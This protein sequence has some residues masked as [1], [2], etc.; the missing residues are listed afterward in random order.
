LRLVSLPASPATEPSEPSLRR[1]AWLSIG[2]ALLTI[3][4]KSLAYLAT[5]S[6]GL[7]SDALESL[8]NLVAAIVALIVL[9]IAESPADEEH[10]WGHEK[11]EYFSSGFEGAAILAAAVA[12]MFTAI[13]RL[14]D[15]KPLESVGLGL[16]ISV[17]ASVVN[18]V[19][20]RILLAAG[21]KHRS[22]TLEADGHH[23]MTDVWTSVGVVVGVGLVA[24]TDIAWL[25]PLVAI[26]VALNIVWTGWR[27]LVRSAMGLLDSSV[28]K[29]DR[30]GFEAILQRYRDD[31]G[32]EW[33]ALRTRQSGSRR[34][35]TVHLLVPGSWTVQRGHD[36][37][38]RVERDLR[39]TSPKTTVFTHLEP[40]EDDISFH[41][42]G[43]DRDSDVPPSAANEPLV[44]S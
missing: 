11:V 29:D 28:S 32:I 9:T 10:E 22:I 33:H 43:L 19:V 26:G 6:V 14:L 5:G 31:E 1:F 12:I 27:L 21:K 3:A 39:G 30:A 40:I 8:V 15:P 24:L 35:V 4:L 7:L 38:E 16:V 17:L 2:A 34:F 44:K 41:D 36:L 25:D 23:L 18:L 13:P 37:C 42:Q 20:A